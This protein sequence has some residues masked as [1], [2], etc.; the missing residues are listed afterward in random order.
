M[1]KP[2]LFKKGHVDPKPTTSRRELIARTLFESWAKRHPGCLY[3]WSDICGMSPM[4]DKML[5]GWM[6]DA[7]AAIQAIPFEE[8][9]PGLFAEA[10]NHDED[11]FC[12]GYNAGLEKAFEIVMAWR[13]AMIDGL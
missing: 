3:T 9:L 10:R 11:R 1:L 8:D 13:K 7:H 12:H 4:W 2:N 5:L 6:E